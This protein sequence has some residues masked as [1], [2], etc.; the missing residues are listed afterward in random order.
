V[1]SGDGGSVGFG[2]GGSVGMEKL[3]SSPPIDIEPYKFAT[4]LKGRKTTSTKGEMIWDNDD[5][6]GRRFNK[7]TYARASSSNRLEVSSLIRLE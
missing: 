3:M 7:L 1:G 6:E 4:K 5:A 2:T